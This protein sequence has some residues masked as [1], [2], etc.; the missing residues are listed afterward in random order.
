MSDSCCAVPTPKQAIDPRYRRVLWVA[1]WVNLAMFAVEVVSS[2]GTGSVSLMADAVD[3]A[4]DAANYGLSIGA[5]AI[6][7]VWRSRVAQLKGWT[8]VLFGIGVLCFAASNA[9][10]GTV[11]EPVTM[12]LV[13]TIALIANLAVATLLFGFR[14]GDA[15]M[16]SVW[17]CTRNDAIGNLAVMAAALGVF[18]A[19]AGWPDKAV[20]VGM[21]VLG[22]AEETGGSIQNRPW[23]RRWWG[24]NQPLP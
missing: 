1:L 19:G 5:L 13:G 15:D 6:G 21:A 11:P 22:L 23:P 3:F 9:W 4:G 18:G 17:L 16:R 24:S 8:M 7:A 10:I 12:G 2:V 20:A 14:R